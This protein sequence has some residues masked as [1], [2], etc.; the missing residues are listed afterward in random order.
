[1]HASLEE[2]AEVAHV[3]NLREENVANHA[4]IPKPFDLLNGDISLQDKIEAIATKCNVTSK[5][6]ENAYPCSPM[7]ESLVA[8]FDET[9]NLYMRQFVFKLA[10]EVSLDRFQVAWQ[11]TIRANPVL[12]TR[13]CQLEGTLG[14]VQAVMNEDALWNT[15]N[16]DLVQF[17]ERD[18][19]IHM[20]LG[21]PFFRYTTVIDEVYK[22]KIQR[23]FIWTVH[24]ALC[25]GV[26][27]PEILD[28]V[29]R[30][31]RDE[32]TLQRQPF[33]SFIQSS[34][35]MPDPW[36]EQQFWKESLSGITPTPYPPPSQAPEFRADPFSALERSL[37]L[38]CLP[39]FGITKALLLRT[40]WAIL[41]SH[42]T[43]TEDVGFGAINNG[44]TSAVPGVSQMTGP[45]INLVPIALRIDPKQSVASLLSQVR[46]QAAEMTTFEHSGMSK[47][48]KYLAGGDSTAIDL[49]T[50]FVVH[51][52]GFSD[53]IAP[54]LQTLGLEYLDELGKKEQ[55]P[56]PLVVT[57]TL[58]TD[59]TITVKIQ[60]DDKVVSTQQ[61]LNLIHQL[62]TV[63]TQLSKATKDTLLESISP[64]GDHDIA[65]IHQWN[66]FTPP[67]E[68]TCIHHLFQKQVFKQPNAVAVC[69]LEQSLTYSKVDYYS[70][71][72]AVNLI[73]LG[74]RPGTF[75]GVCFEKSIWTVV[76]ILAVFKAGCV[77]VPID[78]AHPRG[79]IA[80]VVKMVQ[81]EIAIASTSS[82]GVLEGL[83]DQI[84]TVDDHPLPLSWVDSPSKSLPSSTA[85]LL[86][87]SG[88]TGKPKGILMSHSAICTSIIHHGPAFGAGPHWR[89]LQFGSHTF[90]L[91]IAEF[92]TTLAF[93]GCICVLSEHDRLNNLAGAI[94][95][96]DANV[97]LVVPTV[98]NLLFPKDVPTL[99][100]IV[101]GG[102]PIT[103]ETLV[104]WADHV[105]LTDAYGPSE[106]AVYCSGNVKVSADA[107]PAHIGRSIGAT[108]W[109]VNP[110]NY[111]QLCAIGCVGEIVISGALLGGGYFSDKV[112]TDAAFVPAPDWLKKFDPTSPYKMLYRSGDL[113][114]YNSDGTFHIVGR[115]DTQVKL[116]GF[117][118]E[119]SE[120]ENQIMA[121]GTVT[122]ALAALPT[123]G[124]CARQIVVVVSF[125]RSDLENHS[126]PNI[127]ISREM[128]SLNTKSLLENLKRHLSL[129]LPDYMNPSIWI[130][131]E[132]MPLL[133]S[134][135]IDR[136][137][138][139]VWM[140]D[141]NYEIYK[142]LVENPDT[143]GGTEIVP[144]S[145]ADKLRQLW[146]EVLNLPTEHIGMNTSFFALGGDSIAA[147]QVV[148]QA[149]ET[150]L[151]VT[152]RGI[153]ST[154]TLGNLVTLIEQSHLT[155]PR[156]PKQLNSP[157]WTSDI[158]L[159]YEQILMSRLRVKPSVKVEDAYPLSP[160]QREI[161]KQRAINPAVFLLSWQMEISS[162]PQQSISL[163]KLVRS[164]KRVVQ[165]YPILRSIFL[166]DPT[167]KLPALQVVLA[168]AEPEVA[169]SSALAGETEPTFETTRTPPVDECFLPHR[170]HF[171]QYGDRFFV[172][173]E[174]DHLV[175]DGWSLKLIKAAFL[176]AYETEEAYVPEDPPSYKA[177]V[178]AHRPDRVDVDSKY[179]ASVLRDQRRALLS[180]PVVS[181]E[182]QRLPSPN[183]DIIYLPVIKAQAL[184]AFSVKNGITPAS[185]FD[186]AWA[187]TLSIYT[188]SP[189]VTFEY[190]VSGR[191]DDVPGIF[192]IVGPLINVLAYHLHGISTES[193]PLELARLAQ[194]MQEQRA[195]DSPHTSSNVREVIEN[196]LKVEKLFN[197]AVNFQRRPTA[198]ETDNL[199]IDDNLKKS[200]D[201][202]HVS[203]LVLFSSVLNSLFSWRY[204][205]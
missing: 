17:L 79:R 93:G 20:P 80:E 199:R 103:K 162:R 21:D 4:S 145:L 159:P 198:V 91:S 86:F 121:H 90:D 95:S 186:A 107:H 66:K 130:V 30:R 94:T 116:R 184:T 182:T 173:I 125:N 134:G 24:H 59:T 178:A 28:D 170:A 111:H 152:V 64:L 142:E 42:Y 47:I 185:I 9:K 147:I 150:G 165:K 135:K 60:H 122:A 133:I 190:V 148:S 172:H 3:V 131:L 74:V 138:I 193:S 167:G 102:E 39:P 176:G 151:P 71:S 161:M 88:S 109:I 180:L 191:D 70:S 139:K 52:K 143:K 37:T 16:I 34:A 31:F 175:I 54:A 163:D 177:F 189:D 98:A 81:I 183:K 26:S 195:Q 203:C 82:A 201:P 97:L 156:D 112:T 11:D 153:I 12:R 85:Y 174:L 144:G 110:D 69:S 115:R 205:Y 25:D 78:P 77:Y 99:K 35:V 22:G 113:A 65:Q 40:A 129:T 10:D 27:I 200:R 23:H 57:F 63:L 171:S 19:S 160:V 132:K 196:D 164:W 96:L 49:Q 128:H 50:L 87:T 188:H 72:F 33:E 14:Y 67:A 53:A 32:P 146:S 120:V 18:A 104:R 197:T 157:Q 62:Q 75:V 108:M 1:M 126:G 13:I 61:A 202:W 45:T 194:Q 6:I 83:C 15:V 51:P 29:S 140:D 101:L 127:T 84:I 179:W 73:E 46:V 114:R 92:F 168:N 7:Q 169:I 105:D 154:K 43:G 141:M 76:A 118:I 2:M 38:E 137:A 117:R 48:R 89:T 36:R 44:R 56:Y 181:H 41:L 8:E 123:K 124:P 149:K 106:T 136:K 192:D 158:L 68:E 155:V 187:Q 5:S 204:R 166:P 58:S 119:L 55:H 100:T